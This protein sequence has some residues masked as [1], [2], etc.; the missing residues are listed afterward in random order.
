MHS[1]FLVRTHNGSVVID[2]G[3]NW[4]V[5]CACGGSQ[6]YRGLLS[7]FSSPNWGLASS[8]V[9]RY[10][11]AKICNSRARSLSCE[12]DFAMT[13]R[14][15]LVYALSLACLLLFLLR[16]NNCVVFRSHVGSSFLA[17]VVT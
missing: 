9:S 10:H 13:C 2:S 11:M 14:S 16:I 12:G 8:G 17:Q 3:G 5:A 6:T 7:V 15:E 4:Y 1:K